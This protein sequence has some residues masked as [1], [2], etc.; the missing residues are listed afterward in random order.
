MYGYHIIHL[1]DPNAQ[2]DLGFNR[3]PWISHPYYILIFQIHRM[4]YPDP[5]FAKL[6]YSDVLT[7]TYSKESIPSRLTHRL[8]KYLTVPKNLSSLN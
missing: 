7:P 1:F 8:N 2:E 3:Q 6:K 5:S 4:D